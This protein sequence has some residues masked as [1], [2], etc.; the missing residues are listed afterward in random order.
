MN[1]TIGWQDVQYGREKALYTQLRSVLDDLAEK[2][3]TFSDK[4]QLQEREF[5]KYLSHAIKID[6][7]PAMSKLMVDISQTLNTD[8]N[9]SLFMFQSPIA[10]AMCL[11]RYE[12]GIKKDSGNIKELVILVSQHFLN[13]LG[14][15]EQ[16]SILGHELGHQLYGHVN[17]PGKVILESEFELED[18]KDAK[19][20]VLRWMICTE[21]SCDIIGFL[22]C[23]QDSDAFY[24]TLLKYTTGLSTPVLR[25]TSN[26]MVSLMLDQFNE[27]SSSM[28]DA[29]LTTHPVIPLRL[30]IIQAI[31]EANLVKH[32]GQ[33]VDKQE[34]TTYQKEFDSIIDNEIKQIYPEMIPSASGETDDD[35]FTLC[36]AVALADGKIT[37]EE[38]VA[39]RNILDQ[40]EEFDETFIKRIQQDRRGINVKIDEIVGKA[41]EN[42]KQSGKSRIEIVGMLRKLLM[43]AASD[44]TVDKNE[45]DTIYSFAKEF[46]ISKEELIFLLQQLGIL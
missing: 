18:V 19:S 32:F 9:L 44:G 7:L 14:Y 25:H 17:I 41:A 40:K 8:L 16:L 6:E 21:V 2:Y 43:V 34:L 36:I 1:V 4:T 46:E 38:V 26:Q 29:I 20:N 30:K 22:S 45:L 39:I 13:D 33:R 3:Q 23:H 5:F 24:N 11:P 42:V 12:I 10:N 31:S 15:N 27:L 37:R 28:F 35:L